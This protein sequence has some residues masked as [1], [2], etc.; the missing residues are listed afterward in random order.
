MGHRAARHLVK[1]IILGISVRMLFN[2]MKIESVDCVKRTV[3]SN[4]DGPYT[5]S[6]RSETTEDRPYNEK[7]SLPDLSAFG[8]RHQV[9]FTLRPEVK[10]QLFQ[11]LEIAN[12]QDWNYLLSGF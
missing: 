11:G 3:L 9:L 4:A 2:K 10:H 6:G 12:T 7:L 8:L 1:K 5:I